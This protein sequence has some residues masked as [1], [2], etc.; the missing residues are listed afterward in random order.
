MSIKYSSIPHYHFSHPYGF[1][2]MNI[3]ASNQWHG[4]MHTCQLFQVCAAHSL[5]TEHRVCKTK[6][7][8]DFIFNIILCFQGVLRVPDAMELSV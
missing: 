4:H 7:S 3:K 2:F 5:K 1:F 6:I 8:R